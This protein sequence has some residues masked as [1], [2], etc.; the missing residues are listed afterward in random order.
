MHTPLQKYLIPQARTNS[1]IKEEQLIL[2]DD[3]LNTLITKYCRESGVRH[4][5][6]Q[7]EKVCNCVRV[8]CESEL[9][10]FRSSARRR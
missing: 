7:I 3:A 6:K 2:N 9:V 4:L 5:Q 10:I 8:K 1:G